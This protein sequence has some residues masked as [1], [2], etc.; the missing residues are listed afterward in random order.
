MKQVEKAEG[1][2][3]LHLPVELLHDDLLH[4]H[5]VRHCK[6]ILTD[7]NQVTSQRHV[8]LLF[9][10]LHCNVEAAQT[11]TGQ[12]FWLNLCR[13][14]KQNYTSQ[15]LNSHLDVLSSIPTLFMKNGHHGGF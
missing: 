12:V 4:P 5:H 1:C 10:G 14:E 7:A 15:L 13:A 2:R 8:L 9:R 3:G 6:A 11:H